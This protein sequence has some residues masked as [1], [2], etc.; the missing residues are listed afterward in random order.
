LKTLL[1]IGAG[2]LGKEVVDIVR[3][4]PQEMEWDLAFVDDQIP[5]GTIVN[6]VR[7]IGSRALLRE[8][9]PEHTGL[10]VAVGLPALRRNLIRE[11]EGR[12]FS[13]PTII[14]SSALIR[15]SAQVEKGVIVGARAFVSCDTVIGSHAVINPGVCVGHDVMIGPYAVI[16][17]GAL[18]S[19]GVRIGEGTLVGAGASVLAGTAVGDWATVGMGAAV[20]SAVENG[21]TVLGNPAKALPVMRK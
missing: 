21:I 6:G 10:C 19:G 7:V 15:P 16:G 1:I 5:V 13:F 8:M 18:L 12:G 2:G 11:V 3:S 9:P 17:G 20:F 14:D 4:F